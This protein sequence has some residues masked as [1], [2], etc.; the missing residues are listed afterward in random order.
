M[1]LQLGAF[2]VLSEDPGSVSSTFMVAHSQ[3]ELQVHSNSKGIALVELY[4]NPLGRFT[5]HSWWL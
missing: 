4:T 3:L 5:E 1:A 2:A